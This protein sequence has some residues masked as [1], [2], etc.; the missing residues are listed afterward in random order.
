[1]VSKGQKRDAFRLLEGGSPEKQLSRPNGADLSNDDD[2]D[3]D[4]SALQLQ[5]EK[6]SDR[7]KMLGAK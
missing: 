1:M 7:N 4:P 2:D 5:I 3:D 6:R